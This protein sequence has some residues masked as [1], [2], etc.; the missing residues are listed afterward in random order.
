M[1]LLGTAFQWLVCV[2]P[3][4]HPFVLAVLDEQ[5]L[6]TWGMLQDAAAALLQ[7]KMYRE[8][9]PVLSRRQM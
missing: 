6:I 5:P 8:A 9:F 2:V 1:A 3:P 4:T 7:R